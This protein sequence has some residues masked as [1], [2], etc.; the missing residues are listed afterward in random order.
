MFAVEMI[1]G[2]SAQAAS[3][4]ADALDFLVAIARR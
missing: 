3:L 2:V 4:M 1:A